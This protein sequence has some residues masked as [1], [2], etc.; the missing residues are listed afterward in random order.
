MRTRQVT[1]APGFRDFSPPTP[2]PL[3]WS[4]MLM[5]GWT[6]LPGYGSPRV[7]S[8]AG[9]PPVILALLFFLVK[10]LALIA[11]SRRRLR[12][13]LRLGHGR[14]PLHASNLPL[15]PQQAWGA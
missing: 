8:G 15:I 10:N 12:H 2:A 7:K 13:E 3:L 5:W 4:V 11:W 6:W 14:M 9:M 1:L